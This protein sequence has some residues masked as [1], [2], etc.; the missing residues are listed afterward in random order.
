[1]RR[2][3]EKG[4]DKYNELA[5]HYWQ[6]V[7]AC[8]ASRPNLLSI[9]LSHNEIDANGRS[10]V[11]TI[12]KMLDDKIT[13]EGMFTTVLHSMICDDEYRFMTQNDG[14]HMAKS[15]IDMFADKLIDNDLLYV[16]QQ[17]ENYFNDGE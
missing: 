6:I 15:P 2:T 11:K 8:I 5:S 4:Y 13:I 12:G 7:N 1:M 9:F 3:S 17:V 14:V 16:K 10:K